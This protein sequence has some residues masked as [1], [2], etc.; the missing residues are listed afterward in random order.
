M[1]FGCGSDV[2]RAIWA[3][4]GRGPGVVRD[5]FGNG[6][7]GVHIFFIFKYVYKKYRITV[8]CCCICLKYCVFRLNFKTLS[9]FQSIFFNFQCVHIYIYIYI[10]SYW[11][12]RISSSFI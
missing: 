11:F 1:W 12:Y 6:L 5:S 4:F 2:V 8:I 10:Y 9:S 7:I 3:W